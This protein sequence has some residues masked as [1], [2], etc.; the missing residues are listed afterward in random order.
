[1]NTSLL[2][3][4]R[5]MRGAHDRVERVYDPAAFAAPGDD[6]TVADPVRLAFDLDKS[7]HQF[8]LVGNVATT[9]RVTCGRCL[10]SFRFP[11]SAD[12]DLVY[13]PHT[14]NVGA[15]EEPVEDEDLA[16]AFYRDETIDLGQLIRE[17]FYLALP[18]KPL[19]QEACKGLCP[20]CGA[21]LNTD[22]CGCSP[23]WTD[24]RLATLKAFTQKDQS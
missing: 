24:P 22:A 5:Q 7:G 14:E 19:C 12:F 3:D 21:N 2:L 23:R 11:V 13:L 17:Q 9:L 16:T 6:L 10:E 1:M 15:G 4:L 20:Q 8:R 18:M